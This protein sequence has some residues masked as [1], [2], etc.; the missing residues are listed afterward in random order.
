ML[1]IP[2]ALE[3][4]EQRTLDIEHRLVKSVT[5]HLVLTSTFG[6]SQTRGDRLTLRENYPQQWWPRPSGKVPGEWV[7]S[8]PLHTFL[9]H[10]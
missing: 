8:S 2:T 7:P 4:Q 6:W 3:C 10:W 5:L 1:T 9:L